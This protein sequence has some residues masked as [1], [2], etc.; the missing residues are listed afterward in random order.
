MA[1]GLWPCN[2]KREQRLYDQGQLGVASSVEILMANIQRFTDNPNNLF[3]RQ[4]LAFVLKHPR[5]LRAGYLDDMAY[6]PDS[7]EERVEVTIRGSGTIGE[8]KNR[9]QRNLAYKVLKRKATHLANYEELYGASSL[10]LRG[11]P[12]IIT[13]GM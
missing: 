1:V 9:A 7:G 2:N 10:T 12:V 8:M 13:S 4:D 11:I 5:E 3:F 6:L